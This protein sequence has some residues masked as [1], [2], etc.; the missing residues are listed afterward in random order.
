MVL[1]S[2]MV[3]SLITACSLM[4]QVERGINRLYGIERDR[5]T[6]RKYAWAL[7]MTLT[8]GL[9][10]AGAFAAIA[11]GHLAAAS[12]DSGTALDIWELLR[13][14][15]GLLLA[16]AG[17]ALVFRWSPR[18][19][20]PAWSWLTF[21]AFVS[22]LLWMVATVGLNVF[23]QRGSSIGRTYGS[24]AGLVALSLW[25]FATAVATLYGAAIAAQ[26]EAVRAGDPK[27]LD[28][29]EDTAD[30]TPAMAGAGSRLRAPDRPST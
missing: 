10:I 11:L 21:G 7:V 27:P 12:F 22:V 18:R 1:V 17:T 15:V 9:L 29:V 30:R 4:G 28:A 26:L 24:L 19:R 20:Q 13:W 6:A 8:A 2:L 5:P 25:S 23:F 16:M 14:P 3:S